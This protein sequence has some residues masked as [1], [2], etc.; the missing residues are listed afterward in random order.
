M[1]I[2]P[3]FSR[4]FFW[5]MTKVSAIIPAAGSGKRMGGNTCKQ[6]LQIGGRPIILETL[7]LFQKAEIITDI[8]LVVS[9]AEVAATKEM[10]KAAGITKVVAVTEGGA[11]RQNSIKN[12][13]NLL[14][15][16][17]E[18]VIVHDGVRPFITESM[19]ESSVAAA[20]E[21]GAAIVAVPVKDT[22]KRAKSCTVTETVPREELWLAQT[23]QAFRY[24][25]IKKAYLEAEKNSFVG[26]DDASLVEAIGARVKIIPG[27][28]ENIKI[29]TPEDLIFAE[30][31]INK[32][33]TL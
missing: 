16:D 8:I 9:A 33:S 21:A 6:Y 5:N 4:V 2:F 28:Y 26:T 25:I 11:E 18:I 22:V 15:S 13:L 27:S 1:K 20:K 32:R 7:S 3:G 29:T 12:G 30:A 17:T 19:I 10:V 31:L 14:K 23:P 24:D